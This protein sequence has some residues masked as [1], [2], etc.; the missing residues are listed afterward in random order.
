M[1]IDIDSEAKSFQRTSLQMLHVCGSYL[2]DPHEVAR[3]IFSLFPSIKELHHHTPTAYEPLEYPW[4]EVS[5]FL[6]D[7][8]ETR[9]RDRRIT[10]ATPTT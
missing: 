7:F 10:Q 9:A 5:G 4:D 3:I 1:N 6:R 8:E 2:E